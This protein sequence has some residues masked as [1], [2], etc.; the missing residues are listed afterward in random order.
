MSNIFLEKNIFTMMIVVVFIGIGIQSAF[1]VEPSVNSTSIPEEIYKNYNCFVIGKAN[2]TQR[3]R[4][5]D[6]N[7]YRVIGFGLRISNEQIRLPSEGWIYTKGDR[8]E[9]FYKGKFW[10]K[11]GPMTGIPPQIN[12]HIGIKN[13]HGICLGGITALNPFPTH[14][15]GRAHA[16]EIINKYPLT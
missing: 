2:H 4:N 14:F 12:S 10:G 8:G 5:P 7:F 9:W 15:I 1:A 6:L 3:G 13:F 16:V 11:L